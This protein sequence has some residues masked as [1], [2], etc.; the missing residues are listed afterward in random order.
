MIFSQNPRRIYEEVYILSS[1]N[2]DSNYVMSLTPIERKLYLSFVES[3]QKSNQSKSDQLQNQMPPP[4]N[5]SRAVDDLAV[6]FGD[7]PP[8]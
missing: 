8:K 2:L 5:H 3:Q 7:I 1:F 4:S 6:E